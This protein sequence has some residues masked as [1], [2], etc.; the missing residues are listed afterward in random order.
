MLI[1]W[2]LA[3]TI[4]GRNAGYE[5]NGLQLLDAASS[6]SNSQPSSSVQP[7]I[8]P[9]SN[10]GQTDSLLPSAPR[11]SSCNFTPVEKKSSLPTYESV[12][13]QTTKESKVNYAPLE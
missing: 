7:L 11:Y 9:P 10:H 2:K 12:M 5:N 13:A 1:K 4:Q 6:C 8:A 3:V